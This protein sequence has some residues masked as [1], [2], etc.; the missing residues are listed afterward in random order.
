MLNKLQY[1][2][3]VSAT[4]TH[5]TAAVASIAGA[6]GYTHCA[7][8]V[9]VSSDKATSIL[10][11]KSGTTTI[12]QQQV[13]AGQANIVFPAGLKAATGALLSAEIDGTAACKANI[14]AITV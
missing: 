6:A 5:A 12:W 3:Q 8:N 7:M 11:I 13:G 14:T 4:A 2:T 9:S 10:L 1:G